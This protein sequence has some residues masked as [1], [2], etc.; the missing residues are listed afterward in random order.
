MISYE[1]YKVI[2]L[3]CILLTVAGLAVGYYST[4]PK[5]IKIIS[6]I[7]SLLILVSGMGLLA[8]LGVSHGEGFPGW[9]MVKMMIWLIIAVAGPV[10]AKRLSSSLK[11]KAFWGL[12]LLFF[13][14]IYFAVNK[15]F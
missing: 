4:Q 6:G 2:H 5:H 14:A 1:V 10:L 9:V 13:I 15:S 12:I 8:R 11:P 3:L 7:T